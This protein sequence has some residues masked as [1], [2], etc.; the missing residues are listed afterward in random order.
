[1]PVSNIYDL[2][3]NLSIS[4]R[5]IS[6]TDKDRINLFYADQGRKVIFDYAKK[7]KMIP[8]IGHLFCKLEMDSEFWSKYVELY[9]SRNLKIIEILSDIF[10]DFHK[11]NIFNIFLYENFG[12][13]ISSETYIALF[14]SGDVDLYADVSNKNEIYS[15]MENHCFK[16][17]N[18]KEKSEKIKTEFFNKKIFEKGYKVNVMWVPMSRLKLPFNMDINNCISVDSLKKYKDTEITLPSNEALMYLCLLHI[19]IHSFSRSPDIRLYA[20]IINMCKLNVNW[21]I[22]MGY[23]KQDNTLIRVATAAILTKKMFNIEIPSFILDYE[24]KQSEVSKLIKLV[25]DDNKD[26]LKY[27]PNLM[28]ILRIETYSDGKGLLKGIYDIIFP[29]KKWVASYYEESMII[30]GYSKHIVNLIK[31]V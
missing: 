29:E 23:A 14:A 3:D 6:I 30:K 16:P 17:T 19:S 20:D 15:I 1:M 21:N 18:M 7:R 25:Y 9:E 5:N 26:V 27:N 10:K 22:I 24:N 11:A 2:I 8:F 4:G 12:A 31:G 13:L 28:D